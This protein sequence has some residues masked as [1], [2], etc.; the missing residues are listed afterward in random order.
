MYRWI[1]TYLSMKIEWNWRR[2][3]RNR[4]RMESLVGRGEPYTS[5][6]LVALAPSL[7]ANILCTALVANAASE[8]A[9]RYIGKCREDSRELRVYEIYD[10]DNFETRQAKESSRAVFSAGIYAFYSGDFSQAKRQ[11]MEI[12]RRPGEDGVALHYL[13]LADRYEKQPPDGEVA[14]G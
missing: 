8:Y 5:R 7:D 10:G 6:R 2:I 11:F 1:L 12:A 3:L 9:L 4:R 13:Y 14:L